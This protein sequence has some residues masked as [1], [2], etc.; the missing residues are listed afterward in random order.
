LLSIFNQ[1]GLLDAGASK[2]DVQKIIRFFKRCIPI[3][4]FGIAGNRKKGFSGASVGGMVR[5]SQLSGNN[6]KEV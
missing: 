4:L 3:R 1:S 2:R 5:P 6:M